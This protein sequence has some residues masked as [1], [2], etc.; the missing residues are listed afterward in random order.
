MKAET[1]D[2]EDWLS[3]ATKEKLKELSTGSTNSEKM[4]IPY[5]SQ[6]T[7]AVLAK[8][9]YLRRLKEEGTTGL[10]QIENI[11][12]LINVIMDLSKEKRRFRWKAFG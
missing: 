2:R 10:L 1:G 3:P 9:E 4:Q 8:T 12:E 7:L 6:L 5:L 11:D